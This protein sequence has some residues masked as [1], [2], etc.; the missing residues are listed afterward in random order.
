MSRSTL[1]FTFILRMTFGSNGRTTLPSGPT[2]SR[3][4]CG[5]YS[6]PPLASAA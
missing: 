4:I 6:V 2:T 1:G 3:T 5:W